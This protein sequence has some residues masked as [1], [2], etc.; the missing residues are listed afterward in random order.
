MNKKLLFS[1]SALVSLSPL[2]LSAGCSKKTNEQKY[3]DELIFNA[4][5]MYKNANSEKHSQNNELKTESEKLTPII[6]ETK[7][8]ASKKDVKSDE[9]K[10]ATDKLVKA[11]LEF[12][13]KLD[14]ANKKIYLLNAKENLTKRIN[15]TQSEE[16]KQ[17]INKYISDIDKALKSSNLETI[18]TLINKIKSRFF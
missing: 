6:N 8:V 1:V 12:Q 3:L 18:T 13:P 5:Q 7:S 2:V 10:T 16:E 11:V 9:I 17:E 4:E 15:P 14:L